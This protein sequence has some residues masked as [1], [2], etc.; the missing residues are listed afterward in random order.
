LFGTLGFSLMGA[1]FFESLVQGY[2]CFFGFVCGIPFVVLVDSVL[3]NL[4]LGG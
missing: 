3:V 2:F 4:L 1:G